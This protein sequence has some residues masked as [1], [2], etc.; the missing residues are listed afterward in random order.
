MAK[1]DKKAEKRE[2]VRTQ[3]PC[4]VCS[5]GFRI[6]E[7][8]LICPECLQERKVDHGKDTSGSDS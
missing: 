5:R 7:M 4:S 2:R 8:G 6:R 1:S 3:V